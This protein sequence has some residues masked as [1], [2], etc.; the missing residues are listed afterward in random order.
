MLQLSDL[1]LTQSSLRMED[2]IEDMVELVANGGRF[3]LERVTYHAKKYGSRPLLIAI[4]KFEDGELYVRDGHHRV[5][6]IWLAGREFLYDDEYVF[7]YYTYKEF[8]EINFDMSYVTP[9]DPRYEVRFGD[10]G[11]FRRETM[12]IY[13][14]L[15][16]AK[17]LKYIENNRHLYCSKRE[18]NF[19]IEQLFRKFSEA[20][21]L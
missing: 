2:Q 15:G 9:F 18:P 16:E 20:I 1:K 5:G 19:G 3:N 11:P 17:A 12:R 21:V 13:N 14:E 7:E 4:N 8:D 10:F 6:S